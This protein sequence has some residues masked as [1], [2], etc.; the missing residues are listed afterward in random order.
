MAVEDTER[1]LNFFH[2][3][4]GFESKPGEEFVS[5]PLVQNGVGAPGAQFRNS[6][7]TLSG[8]TVYWEIVE[9]RNIDRKPFRL[10]ISDPR[11][12]A[13]SLRVRDLDA[14]MMRVRVEG[15]SV[16]SRIGQLGHKPGSIFIR[17]PNGFLLKLIQSQLD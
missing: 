7:A 3:V 16:V 8:G 5:N 11:A 6:R 9:S 13:F 4:F 1:T 17:D 12:P 14:V 2:R 15:G 10:R